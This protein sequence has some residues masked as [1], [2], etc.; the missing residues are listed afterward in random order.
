MNITRKYHN[1]RSQANPCHHEE[2][3]LEHTHTLTSQCRRESAQ[4]W[5]LLVSLYN[6]DWSLQKSCWHCKQIWLYSIN[7]V[8]NLETWGFSSILGFD[9]GARN[10]NSERMC[11]GRNTNKYQFRLCHFFICMFKWSRPS[12]PI[13]LQQLCITM[14]SSVHTLLSI[15]ALRHTEYK[16]SNFFVVYNMPFVIFFG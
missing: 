15:F 11:D 2:S 1:S 10:R 13:A 12:P 4:D 6:N 3:T 16:K 7:Y 8:I 9:A 14:V 5:V